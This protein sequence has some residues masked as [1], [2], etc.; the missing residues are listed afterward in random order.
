MPFF[1]KDN[2]Q[3]LQAPAFVSGPGYNLSDDNHTAQTYPVDGWYWYASLDDA[4]AGM[5]GSE[6]SVSMRQAQLAML[7]TTL[8]NGTN[9]LDAVTAIVAQASRADQITWNSSSR[10]E[11]TNEML[12]RVAPALGLSAADI[13]ALFALAR[14]K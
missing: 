1:K 9:L 13:T 3:L 11:P 5:A 8:A 7:A 6:G 2:G 10:V 4:M 14:T 12:Q